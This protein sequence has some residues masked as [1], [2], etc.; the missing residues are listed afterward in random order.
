MRL[1]PV[2]EKLEDGSYRASFVELPSIYYVADTAVKAGERVERLMHAL[3]SP[4]IRIDKILPDGDVVLVL[5]REEETE[6]A[7]QEEPDGE[8]LNFPSGSRAFEAVMG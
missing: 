6:E 1:T 2:I 3:E 7:A 5:D 4:H 8:V